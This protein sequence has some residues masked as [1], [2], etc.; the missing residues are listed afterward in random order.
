LMDHTDFEPT[1]QI[2]MSSALRI[3]RVQLKGTFDA[4]PFTNTTNQATHDW[5]WALYIEDQDESD[6]ELWG[7]SGNL[8]AQK[9]V[10]KWDYFN[11]RFLSSGETE[12][13]F[14]QDSILSHNGAH[15]IQFDLKFRKP[16]AIMREDRLIMAFQAQLDL[17]DDL[18][19]ASF[20]SFIRISAQLPG[21]GR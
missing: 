3:H 14:P 7:T 2:P 12:G 19:A 10:L 4:I 15:R 8:M 13:N 16:L 6:T 17:T 1:G 18:V 21:S 5:L 11:F 20:N 9:R